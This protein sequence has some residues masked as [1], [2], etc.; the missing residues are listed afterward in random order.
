MDINHTEHYHKGNCGIHFYDFNVFSVY[1]RK[2]SLWTSRYLNKLEL[3]GNESSFEV[4]R[5]IIQKCKNSKTEKNWG[6][7]SVVYDNK[8]MF[9]Y[10][11]YCDLNKDKE[12][13]SKIGFYFSVLLL[14]FNAIY[15]EYL[16][17]KTDIKGINS[18]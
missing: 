9:S 13:L 12:I 17:T 5:I 8:T 2:G 18:K 1:D 16:I 6:L 11:K 10:L 7:I 4:E 3:E 15:Y 14:L